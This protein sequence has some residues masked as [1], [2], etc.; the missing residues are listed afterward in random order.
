MEFGVYTG[1]GSLPKPLL[2]KALDCTHQAACAE[3]L[4]TLLGLRGSRK[5]QRA[6]V[7]GLGFR[8]QGFGFMVYGL[9]SRV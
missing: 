7:Y 5:A 3:L 4:L 9:G 8:V 6:R 2:R 1:L